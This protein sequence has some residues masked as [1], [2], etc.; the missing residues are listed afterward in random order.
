MYENSLLLNSHQV[1]NIYRK[2]RNMNDDTMSSKRS[3][4]P[5]SSQLWLRRIVVVI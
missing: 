4:L 5:Y 2:M 3:R 1:K